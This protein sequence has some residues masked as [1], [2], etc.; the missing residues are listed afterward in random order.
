M[1][2]YKKSFN[3]VKSEQELIMLLS[4][5]LIT[6]K[7]LNKFHV[8]PF[9]LFSKGYRL[10]IKKS[11]KILFEG[12]IKTNT[13]KLYTSSLIFST[14]NWTPIFIEGDIEDKRISLA[15]SLSLFNI[16]AIVAF[17]LAALIIQDETVKSEYISLAIICIFL[18]QIGFKILRINKIFNR[19]CKKEVS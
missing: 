9:S 8:F 4:K 14:H 16:L 6:S 3:S 7:D 18:L 13:F 11:L 1:I 15:Y 17:S 5:R 10:D 2:I 12:E 19:I